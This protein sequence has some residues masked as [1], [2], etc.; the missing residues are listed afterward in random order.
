MSNTE[1]SFED[2]V[3][4]SIYSKFLGCRP[5]CHNSAVV[6]SID[7]QTKF[8]ACYYGC[9]VKFHIFADYDHELKTGYSRSH[10]IAI[11][12]Y[13]ENYLRRSFIFFM[14]IALHHNYEVALILL[15]SNKCTH[16]PYCCY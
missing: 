9:D 13:S 10:H 1:L 6:V 11:L 14:V 5:N 12:N 8:H 15:P 4:S 2:L 3:F 16:P 7:L